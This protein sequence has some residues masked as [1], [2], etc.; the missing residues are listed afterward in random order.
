MG[1]RPSYDELAKRIAEHLATAE[2]Q[3]E[4]VAACWDGYLGALLEWGLITP[5]DHA[6]L[7]R[8]LPTRSP[9]PVMKIFLGA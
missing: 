6:R 5:G 8:L 9:N 3:E 1:D 4:L 7:G 2:S